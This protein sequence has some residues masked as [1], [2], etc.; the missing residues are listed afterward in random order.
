MGGLVGGVDGARLVFE[1]STGVI[2]WMDPLLDT[3]VD[4]IF[5]LDRPLPLHGPFPCIGYSILA[6]NFLCSKT[7]VIL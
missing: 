5:S 4:F 6:Y 7:E 1:F 2:S 3:K